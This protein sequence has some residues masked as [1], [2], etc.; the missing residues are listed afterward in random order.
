MSGKSQEFNSK[1]THL[2]T[3]IMDGLLVFISSQIS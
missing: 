1:K 3:E 2:P